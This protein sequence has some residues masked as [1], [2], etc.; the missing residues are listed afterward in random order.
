MVGLNTQSL[1]FLYS[2]WQLLNESSSV[3]RERITLFSCESLPPPPLFF[4]NTIW[5]YNRKEKGQAEN[6]GKVLPRI[7]F[8]FILVLRYK[9]PM[10]KNEKIRE[11]SQRSYNWSK[12]SNAWK[13]ITSDR[14]AFQIGI[15]LFLWNYLVHIV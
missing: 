9:F 11:H 13:S 15:C 8:F 14:S 7:V 3:K 4:L 1:V 12:I 10:P 2:K 6:S 5:D